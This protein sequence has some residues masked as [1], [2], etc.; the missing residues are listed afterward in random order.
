M[1]T[2]IFNHSLRVYLFALRLARTAN[3][4]WIDEKRV[5]LLFT[6][7]IFHDLGATDQHNGE[8]RFEVEGADA[9]VAHLQHYGYSGEETHDV[10]VAIAL[11]TSAG[12]ADRISELALLVRTAV[13]IDFGELERLSRA[14]TVHFG[15]DKDSVMEGWKAHQKEVEVSLPRAG[16]EKVLGDAITDQAMQKQW[17]APAASWPGVLLRAKL[18]APERTGVNPAF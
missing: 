12:I 5:D 10:W 18:A 16:I 8:Q 2:A 14:A 4:A 11:H 7:C 17:K 1:P 13:L 15:L 3:P 6:A 9:A